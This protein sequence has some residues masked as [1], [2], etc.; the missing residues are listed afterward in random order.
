[1]CQEPERKGLTE[2]THIVSA[3]AG[4]KCRCADSQ[5]SALATAHFLLI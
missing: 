4:A 5:P 1:M 3:R 2:I